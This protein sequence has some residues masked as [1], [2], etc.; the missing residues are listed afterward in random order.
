MVV[1]ST[2][3]LFILVGGTGMLACGAL[4]LPLQHTSRLSAEIFIKYALMSLFWFLLMSAA[5]IFC[6]AAN[7]SVSLD[8][9]SFD[10]LFSQIALSC[11]FFACAL[12]LGIV[13]LHPFYVDCA[14]NSAPLAPIGAAARLLAAVMIL[15]RVLPQL[16][17]SVF[18][19]FKNML[20][21]MLFAGMI[22][23][24]LRAT[25]Q[26]T[27]RRACLYLALPL[28]A[29]LL[30]SLILVGKTAH[31]DKYFLQF[32][33]VYLLALPAALGILS[34]WQGKHERHTWEEFAGSGNKYP[35]LAT[36][37]IFAMGSVSGLPGT[38]GFIL[39]Y[40]F[41]YDAYMAGEY[42]FAGVIA[43]C[44]TLGSVAVIKFGIFL[45]AKPASYQMLRRHKEKKPW[46]LLAAVLLLAIAN[47][48]YYNATTHFIG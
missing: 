18:P 41:A 3:L 44:S 13:P 10:H 32:C 29:M 1:S 42:F 26:V 6:Y 21:F 40:H 20:F 14:D 15:S 47:I 46:F 16:N 34:F 39:R 45:F 4:F 43:F 5:I 31:H 22:I 38:L 37:F 8:Q 33:L 9:L 11:L 12:W 36:A 24:V 28:P 17:L 19:A 48:Y 35:L 7:H 2:D 27:V 25:D 23:P 30:M